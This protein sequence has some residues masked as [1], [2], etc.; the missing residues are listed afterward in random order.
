[1][2]IDALRRGSTPNLPS[3]GNHCVPVKNS[4]I[5]TSVKKSAPSSTSTTTIPT[6]TSTE[7]VAAAARASST[8]FSPNRP[9]ALRRARGR[10]GGV[11]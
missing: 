11:T 4:V 3:S 6:V 2:T 7:M 8:A 5:G 10:S 1:M 9:R